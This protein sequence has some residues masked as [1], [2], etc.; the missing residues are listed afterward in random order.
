M[1][2]EKTKR[3]TVVQV[4]PLIIGP[5]NAAAATG[6]PWRWCRDFWQARGRKFVGHG[7]KQGIP[8]AAFLEE[9]ADH[10][11]SEPGLPE[12]LSAEQAADIVRRSL[13]LRKKGD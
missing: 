13:G 10:D 7:R 6:F 3:A 11:S 2:A 9:L 5:A 4:A 1:S 12:S 8:A